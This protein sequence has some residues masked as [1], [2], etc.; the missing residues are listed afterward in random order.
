MNKCISIK[1]SKGFVIMTIIIV[2]CLLLSVS[3]AAAM[4]IFVKT[5]TG[6]TITL[7]V[8]A[9]D[10]IENVKAKIQDKEGIPVDK[11]ILV[12]AGEQLEDGRTLSDYNIQKES[13]LHLFLQI[14][15]PIIDVP[16]NGEILALAYTW[17]NGTTDTYTTNVTVYVNGSITNI[18]VAV[19][20]TNF[21]ISNVPLGADGDYEINVSAMDSAGNINATNS[22]VTV[23]V[24][25]TPPTAPTNLIHTDDAPDGYDNDNS[26]DISWSAAT[27]A[28]STLIYRIYRDGILNSSTISLAYTFAGETEGTHEYN[29]SA[30]DSAGNINTTNASVTVIVDYTDPVIHNVS[31][32]DTSPAYGQAIIVSVNVTDTNLASVTAGS[33]SLTHQ[34]GALWNGTITAGYGTNTV[35]V[36]AYDN[37]SNSATNS[38]LS[39]TGPN[40][41]TDSGGS[42]GGVGVGT[43][44]E[45]ENVEET[46]VLRIYLGAGGSSTYNFNN[47]VTSVEVTP[48]RTYGLVA[49]R[50]EVLAGQPGSITSDL[51]AGVLYKYVNIFVGTSGWAEGKLSDS[52]INFQVPT[53]WCEENN[54]DPASVVMYRHHNGEWELLKSTTKGQAGGYYQYSSPTQGFSTFMILGQVEGS[55][56]GETVA[57]A[58][59][60]TV[61]DS[62]PAPEATSTNGTPGFG[63]LMGIMGILIAVYS[64]RK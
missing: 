49:A 26:T 16:T 9:S 27:D 10:S 53:S 19:S 44:D 11:Q 8:E 5:L 40:E 60:G 64:R 61:A 3:S 42:S 57:T 4:Q 51:P 34:S 1:A 41:P 39:Y 62:T 30:N 23:T 20:G 33:T 46:V 47:V 63:I 15:A 59:S 6:K 21:N 35:T 14:N 7:D 17:V 36:T 43:S 45:P 56:S 29:V 54:I 25:T 37:A 31:L 58:D 32:S 38:S 50:I 24:D 12:F 28:N 2:I 18:S 48:D 13:T 55:S 22:S 52:M